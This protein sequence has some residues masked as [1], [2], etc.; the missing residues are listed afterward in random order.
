MI[1][2]EHLEKLS[3]A[4]DILIEL[5]RELEESI[6]DIKEIL[7]KLDSSISELEIIKYDHFGK[8]FKNHNE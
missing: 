8:Y 2:K 6:D 4:E 3:E 1:N 5:K 7:E